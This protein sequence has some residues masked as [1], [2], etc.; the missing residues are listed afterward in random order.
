MNAILGY[1]GGIIL[2]NAAAAAYITCISVAST[3]APSRHNLINHASEDVLKKLVSIGRMQDAD[4]V[5]AVEADLELLRKNVETGWTTLAEQA[6][7]I[8]ISSFVLG[9]H[10]KETLD[11]LGKLIDDTGEA[12]SKKFDELMD[13][14]KDDKNDR[15]KAA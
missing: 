13:S 15:D 2:A 10:T 5:K 3:A 11:G 4:K 9:A 6:A 1:V 14:K 8:R 7:A 12:L